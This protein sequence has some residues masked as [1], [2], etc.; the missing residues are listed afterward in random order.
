MF[1][2]MEKTLL[3]LLIASLVLWIPAFKSWAQTPITNATELSA[4]RSNLSGS[5][6]LM[7]DIDMSGVTNWTPIGMPASHTGL[8]TGNNFTG[9]LDGNGY[10]IYGLKYSYS[11]GGMTGGLF[12]RITG[13]VRNV[14]LRNFEITGYNDGS[15]SSN[16]ASVGALT[17]VL[18]TNGIAE[19]IAVI[20]CTITGGADGSG[21]SEVGGITGRTVNTGQTVKDCFVDTATTISGTSDVGGLIGRFDIANQ[22]PITNCYVAAMMESTSSNPVYGI[23]GGFNGTSA[24]FNVILRSVF[25]MAQAAQGTTLQPFCSQIN[26]ES[27]FYFAC[28][29]YFPSIAPT[30]AKTLADLQE[31][32]TYTDVGWDFDMTWTWDE[33]GEYPFPVLGKA[34]LS[35]EWNDIYTPEDLRAIGK[36][37]AKLKMKY[38]LMNNI[39]FTGV[40]DWVPLGVET[41]APSATVGDDFNFSGTF[42]GQGYTLS[43]ITVVNEGKAFTS[44]LFTKLASGAV[45][46][47]L[48]LENVDISGGNITGG[49]TGTIVSGGTQITIQNV[50][51][52]G[53]I[54]G[55]GEVGGITG[56]YNN[57]NPILIKDCSVK[58][59]ITGTDLTLGELMNN[60]GVTVSTGALV[61]VGGI[62]GSAYSGQKA[63]IENCLVQGKIMAVTTGTNELNPGGLIGFS[64]NETASFNLTNSV[65]AAEIIGG[66]HPFWGN[67]HLSPNN[68]MNVVSCYYAEIGSNDLFNQVGGFRATLE[69]LMEKQFYTALGWDLNNMWKIIV[70]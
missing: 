36:S 54:K 67:K 3:K 58:A 40:T 23:V 41:L 32:A 30:N 26:S 1:S 39:D 16:N 60:Q 13:A 15:G 21:G 31:E 14:E 63:T 51:V 62:I 33:S 22:L 70:K 35:E 11:G 44:A 34:Q 20:G 53:K 5:Y 66:S 43:N 45:V 7:N 57:A 27:T 59:E 18:G 55:K 47:N 2:Y 28:S 37:A 56:R 68:V 42:D 48:A 24:T 29:E 4:I 61:N 46:K 64:N 8:G 17:A 6:V 9:T 49:L 65:V 12:A 10:A 52:S 38:K 25:V 19:R 50:Y 69:D